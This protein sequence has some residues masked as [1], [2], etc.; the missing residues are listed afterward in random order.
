M[1]LKRTLVLFIAFLIDEGEHEEDKEDVEEEVDA[2]SGI[3]SSDN[4]N[5]TADKS[6]AIG[7]KDKAKFEEF[8]VFSFRKPLLYEVFSVRS[9][10]YLPFP[11]ILFLLKKVSHLQFLA[12]FPR[13]QQ[14]L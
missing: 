5:G 2:T 12:F 9:Q 13:I 10:Q 6:S 7:T 11:M 14:I 4:K 1:D 3:G 8:T